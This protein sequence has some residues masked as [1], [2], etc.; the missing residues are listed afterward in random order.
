[1]I[2]DEDMPWETPHHAWFISADS[3][4]EYSEVTVLGFSAH[5]SQVVSVVGKS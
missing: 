1:M 4:L 5:P 3:P 2:V